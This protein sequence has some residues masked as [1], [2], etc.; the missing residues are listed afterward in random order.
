MVGPC[1][2][3]D[4][5]SWHN[6][7]SSRNG[8]DLSRGDDGP[9]RSNDNLSCRNNDSSHIGDDHPPYGAVVLWDMLEATKVYH[10]PVWTA[11]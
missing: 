2:S 10:R 3:D 11:Q 9:C 8:D 7:D 6:D 4:Y 1:R 5:L